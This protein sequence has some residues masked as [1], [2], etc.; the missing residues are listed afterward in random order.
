MKLLSVLSFILLAGASPAFAQDARVQDAPV[1]SAAGEPTQVDDVVVEAQ[2]LRD[3]AETF[4]REIAAPVR[5]RKAARWQGSVCVGVSGLRGEPA[6]F[7]A[8]RVSDWAYSLGVSVSRPGCQPEV[9]IVFADDGSEAATGLIR[10]NPRLFR[11]GVGDSDRGAAALEAFRR[12]NKP[13]RWWQTSLPT[14]D[15]T[16]LPLRRLPGQRPFTADNIRSPA[17]L[18]TFGNTSG[19][20]S[21]LSD[22]SRDDLVRT[23]VIV[24]RQAVALADLTKIADYVALV[25]L[26]QIDPDAL[27]DAP[28]ILRLFVPGEVQ[29]ETLTRWD[30]AYLEAL[31]GSLQTS[32]SQGS[33][34][35]TIA[36]GLTGRIDPQEGAED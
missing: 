30:R 8:D 20:G 3:A 14:N 26:A 22:T 29:E 23:I 36:G 2:R 16:G 15:D 25:S 10:R 19:F 9:I 11:T 35:S 21:R 13:I 33:N 1:P 27:P 32:A 28:S 7:V 12:S 17:D 34:L 4:V 6:A 18:G 31:Y 5:G 24:D